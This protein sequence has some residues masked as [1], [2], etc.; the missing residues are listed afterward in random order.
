MP[1][2]VYATVTLFAT[3]VVVN[4]KTIVA[5]SF[6]VLAL[7]A[8]A[9]VAVPPLAVVYGSNGILYSLVT[10]GL[11]NALNAVLANALADSDTTSDCGPDQLF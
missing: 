5:P 8:N 10:D 2:I 3:L 4:V 11:L 1:V 6:T 7:L 9:Y